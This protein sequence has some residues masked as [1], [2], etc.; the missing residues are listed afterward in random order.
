MLLLSKLHLFLGMF[1]LLIRI[2]QIALG[3][4]AIIHML[5]ISLC[6]IFY[7]S[8]LSKIENLILNVCKPLRLI[9]FVIVIIMTTTLLYLFIMNATYSLVLLDEASAVQTTLSVHLIFT[10]ITYIQR[11]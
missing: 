11:N 2:L 7:N 1:M 4:I 10:Y 6:L 8:K 5:P 3:V 9:S